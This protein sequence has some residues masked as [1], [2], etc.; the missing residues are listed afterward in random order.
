MT[1][2]FRCSSA[3]EQV[4]LVLQQV[5]LAYRIRCFGWCWC[6]RS[7]TRTSFARAPPW[8]SETAVAASPCWTT[9]ARFS[10]LGARGVLPTRLA[11]CSQCRVS[12]PRRLQTTKVST[13]LARRPCVSSPLVGRGGSGCDSACPAASR[14][15]ATPSQPGRSTASA[16]PTNEC[17][18]WCWDTGTTTARVQVQTKA[19]QEPAESVA[20]QRWHRRQHPH[21]H[22]H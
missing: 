11:G 6:D 12:D 21:H 3:D 16:W 18:P 13:S 7:S 4:V 20:R 14:P 10:A 5:L 22:H 8:Q 15:A 9:T 19:V 2:H 1:A 17:K